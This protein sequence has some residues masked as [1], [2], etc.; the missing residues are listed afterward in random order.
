MSKKQKKRITKLE[1]R[2]NLLW[3]TLDVIEHV[4][5]TKQRDNE[6]QIGATNEAVKRCTER[7]GRIREELEQAKGPIGNEHTGWRG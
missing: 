2:V 6:A 4:M 1:E 7:L 5:V 3:E